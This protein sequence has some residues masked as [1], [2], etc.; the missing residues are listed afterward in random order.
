MQFWT[1]IL[2]ILA[3]GPDFSCS[4]SRVRFLKN[5][6]GYRFGRICTR[7]CHKK[8]FSILL[9][10][11]Y[12]MFKLLFDT[13]EL[14]QKCNTFPYLFSSTGCEAESSVWSGRKFLQRVGNIGRQ[15]LWDKKEVHKFQEKILLEAKAFLL[16]SFLTLTFPYP[17]YKRTFLSSLLGFLLSV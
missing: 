6:T 8:P 14:T 15:Q 11:I 3:T 1:N 16:S 7:K 10:C 13:F 9:F 5:A 2:H 4:S 12:N 17:S